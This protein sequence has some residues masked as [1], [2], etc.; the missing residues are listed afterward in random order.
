MDYNVESES[1]PVLNLISV[2]ILTTGTNYRTKSICV[3]NASHLQRE[4]L[5]CTSN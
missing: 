3:V 1:L 2:I 4:S 5:I